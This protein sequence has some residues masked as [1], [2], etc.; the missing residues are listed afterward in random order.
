VAHRYH[1]AVLLLVDLDGVVYR[2]PEP[3]AGMPALLDDRVA[4]G[5]TVI[6]CTNNSRW[7]RSQYRARLAGL[8]APVEER[9]IVTAARATA[10]LLAERR[11]RV[12][13]VLG[14]PGLGREI[15]D[16]GLRT[17]APTAR[18][19]AER[20]DALAVGVDFSLSYERLSIAA[21]VARS[22]AFFVAT[23][24]DPVFPLPDGLH[25]GAGS[26]VAAVS[27]ASGR[28]PDESVGKPEPRLFLEA[29]ALA[30]VPPSEAIVIGDSLHSDMPAA[31][32]IG[33][34]AILMLTGVTDPATAER[35]E[36]P[37]RPAAIAK[38]ASELAAILDA[39]S[40][41]GDGPDHG[42]QDEPLG[43]ARAGTPATVPAG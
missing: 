14:G 31:A 16:V 34:R 39:W 7:H 9:T 21:D 26:I 27:V 12:T 13:M 8:G 41:R 20:P 30:G 4:R 11:P 36:D 42:T 5:D 3:V 43:R 15:H 33:A 18:G 32:A 37:L 10:L 28:E 38:D 6:Y 25:A 1:R 35:L 29:A 19:R 17:V 23:N 24:R 22:G 40:G 2:G